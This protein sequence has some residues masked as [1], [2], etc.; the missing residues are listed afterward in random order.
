M[1]ETVDFEAVMRNAAA[2][3]VDLQQIAIKYEGL[4]T[5]EL[6]ELG[7][8]QEVTHQAGGGSIL[9]KFPLEGMPLF[10]EKATAVLYLG[11]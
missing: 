11:A 6:V 3:G 1:P 8:H 5:A 4:T 7:S 9:A 2:Q 10:P